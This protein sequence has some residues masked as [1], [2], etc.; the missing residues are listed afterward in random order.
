MQQIPF[1]EASQNLPSLI[2]AAVR[3]EII[4]ITTEDQYIIRLVPNLKAIPPL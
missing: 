1:Q 2:A 4:L 3:G